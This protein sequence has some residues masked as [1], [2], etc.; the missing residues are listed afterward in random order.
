MQNIESLLSALELG[1]PPIASS[2][3]PTHVGHIESESDALVVIETYLLGVLH[4]VHRL[5]RPN[6][7]EEIVRSGNKYLYLEVFPGQGIYVG[8]LDRKLV[9]RYSE[10]VSPPAD[11]FKRWIIFGR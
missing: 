10:R 7:Q 2:L 3:P 6:E 4:H 1:A 9:P 11:I 8:R 5:P